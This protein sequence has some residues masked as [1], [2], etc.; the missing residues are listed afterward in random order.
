MKET[1]KRALLC[2]LLIAAYSLLPAYDVGLVLDQN[3]AYSGS[4]D[5]TL[6]EL[7]GILVPRV[8]GLLGDSGEFFVSAGLNYQNDPWGVI[9]ELIEADFF[10]GFDGNSFR[11]G[12]SAYRDPLGFIVDGFFDGAQAVLDTSAGVFSAAAMYAGFI[13]KRRANI[14]MTVAE[15]NHNNAAIEPGDIFNTYFA[16]SRLIAALEWEHPL[17]AQHLRL[18]LA[19]IAQFDLSGEKLNSQYILAKMTMPFQVFSFEAGACFNLIQFSGRNETA[20]AA[21]LGL[22]WFWRNQGLSFLSRFSSGYAGGITPFLPVTTVTQGN[23]FTTSMIGMAVFS[24]DYSM[25]LSRDLSFSIMPAYFIDN[26]D[27][28]SSGLLG[29]EAY[30]KLNWSPLSDLMFSLGGGAFLPSLGNVASDGNALWR[31]EMNVVISL[32]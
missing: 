20:F 1:G 2:C 7:N 13:C 25:R 18:N 22:N 6:F 24:L 19:A 30:A 28:D 8:S 17:M 10:F 21:E 27:D 16:P 4:G 15:Y 23:V 5:E 32:F 12:R 3:L 11:I 14:E 26:F 31:M 9:P 29:A